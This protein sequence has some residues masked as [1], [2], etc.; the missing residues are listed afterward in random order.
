MNAM[1]RVAHELENVADNCFNLMI[2]SQ[3]R[4]DGKIEFDSDALSGLQPYTATVQEFIAFI[5]N[6]LG[7]HLPSDEL[8]RAF[9]MEREVNASRNVLRDAA[10]A[11]MQGGANVQAELL[12]VDVV[13]QIEHIGD[14][15]LNIAQALRQVR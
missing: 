10:Q 4:H 1:I 3:R 2:L 15:S 9:A 8:E 6:H 5:K 14:H 13:R 12:F 7:E 11:R